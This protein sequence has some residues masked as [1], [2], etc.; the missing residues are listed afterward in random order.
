MKI[1]SPFLKSLFLVGCII[2]T[3]S[4]TFGRVSLR[5]NT[6][7][8]PSFYF[9]S[10]K[11][12]SDT[13]KNSLAANF[14]QNTDADGDGIS[15]EVEGCTGTVIMGDITDAKVDLLN[16][17]GTTVFNLVQQNDQRIPQL[18]IRLVSKSKIQEWKSNVS[19]SGLA[20]NSTDSKQK[21]LHERF[22][23][24]TNIKGGST[25]KSVTVNIDFGRSAKSLS[26]LMPGEHFQYI[27]G[28]KGLKNFFLKDTARLN[29]QER[30]ITLNSATPG[31]KYD[32][33]A[34][35]DF[36]YFL[37]QEN[38]QILELELNCTDKSNGIVFGIY[39]R[40]GVIDSDHDGIPDYLDKDSD[41]DGIPDTVETGCKVLG[42]VSL[43]TSSQKWLSSNISL[44]E[45]QT[46]KIS[47]SGSI[48]SLV[49]ASGGPENGKQFYAVTTSANLISDYSG[50]RYTLSEDHKT[51]IYK[52]KPTASIPL[53]SSNLNAANYQTLLTLVGM[54]D[55]NGN[56]QFDPETDI[57]IPHLAEM[58]ESTKEDKVFKAE[59]SGT[60]YVLF[61]D[62][63]YSDNTGI[64]DLHI[65]QC[66]IIIDTDND[67]VPDHLDVDSD[68]DG[69]PDAVEGSGNIRY[70]QVHPLILDANDPNV[71]YSGQIKFQADGFT[72]GN[73][74]KVISRSSEAY[75]IPALAFKTV[76]NSSG[77]ADL[78]RTTERS[79]GA[80]NKGTSVDRLK[81]D[82]D[83]TRCFRTATSTGNASPSLHG[84]TSLNRPSD[85]TWPMKITGAQMVLDAK[86][87]G[88]VLNRVAFSGNPGV[89]V[90]IPRENFVEGMMV[91]D[92]TNNCLKIYDG[93]GWFCFTKQTCD[94]FSQ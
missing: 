94:D 53:Q 3:G 63:S 45:G 21:N 17:T 67:S 31:L 24:F 71:N 76:P 84:I 6:E 78:S 68:G 60:L 5:L 77:T 70:N 47:R 55:H 83:C 58:T 41:N 62:D 59:R 12:D 10:N 32:D 28:I 44:D 1:V 9:R 48:S 46:Y 50:N 42:S 8:V 43:N 51:A 35:N 30:L 13:L 36:T 14:L 80:Q 93:T 65:E 33:K 91:Y 79:T 72:E 37:V 74:S 88:F 69:C 27:I 22:L 34:L 61:T 57:L 64:W 89:P 29:F 54:I 73:P 39:C 38:K 2:I 16:W 87:K 15:D 56:G 90:G 11:I 52:E 85:G 82:P 66:G 81:R 7:Q 25:D 92:V 75:G 18:S 20:I 49:T 23:G 4:T 86:T 40:K 26:S 19:S